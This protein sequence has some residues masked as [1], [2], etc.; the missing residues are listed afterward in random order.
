MK[1]KLLVIVLI[2]LATNAFAGQYLWQY[3]W[4]GDLKVKD[5]T[6]I[7]EA[8]KEHLVSLGHY[9]GGGSNNSI[10]LCLKDKNSALWIVESST[11][12]EGYD[13]NSKS[14]DN[15]NYYENCKFVLD[16]KAEENSG[17]NCEKKESLF[18]EFFTI[19]DNLLENK[20]EFEDFDEIREIEPRTWIKE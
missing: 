18:K 19:E 1:I 4:K 2:S 16:E 5:K 15:T 10:Y 11:V 8:K 3:T 14:T 7:C 6:Y 13:E 20:Q 17:W 9:A 12:W